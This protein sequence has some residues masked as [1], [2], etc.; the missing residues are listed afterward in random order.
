MSSIYDLISPMYELI[1]HT[2][3][4]MYDYSFT[5]GGNTLPEEATWWILY[6]FIIQL[7]NHTCLYRW[8]NITF[9]TIK[10]TYWVYNVKFMDSAFSAK[11]SILYQ[12]INHL[13]N[14]NNLITRKNMKSIY[15]IHFYPCTIP[16]KM[17]FTH[18]IF[19]VNLD[20]NGKLSVMMDSFENL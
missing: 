9:N 3:E 10:Q 19:L 1:I 18:D 2:Y 11:P 17:T 14:N 15:Q 12:N 4:L 5:P 20:Y 13:R 16:V 7:L 8:C 6:S